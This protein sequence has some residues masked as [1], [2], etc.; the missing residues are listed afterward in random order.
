MNSLLELFCDIDDF[1]QHFEEF[2]HLQSLPRK[3]SL[4]L[5]HYQINQLL[6][7]C[8]CIDPESTIGRFPGFII[9]RKDSGEQ[10]AKPAAS[11]SPFLIKFS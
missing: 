9:F 8:G 11:V 6:V 2:T 10:V 7:T 4:I 1:C 3:P 5:D